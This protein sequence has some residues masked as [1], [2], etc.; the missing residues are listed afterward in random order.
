M[1]LNL[2]R[3]DDPLLLHSEHFWERL[4]HVIGD[5]ALNVLAPAPVHEG[6]GTDLGPHSSQIRIR[7]CVACLYVCIC[8][9]S[10][11][12]LLEGNISNVSQC[13]L[14]E[15]E[16]TWRSVIYLYMLRK[17]MVLKSI[18]QLKDTHV[19]NVVG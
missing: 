16:T 3:S 13:L 14:L 15:V 5:S 8:L 19:Q 17:T 4:L 1:K 12:L 6:I 18:T 10:K 2:L 11:V 9:L 7:C